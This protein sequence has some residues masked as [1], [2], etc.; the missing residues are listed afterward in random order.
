M[1]KPIY[2]SEEHRT[3]VDTYLMV[4]QDFA[5][6]VSTKSKYNNYLDV[7]ET[8]IEYHNSYG[9]GIRENN[10]Y[11]WLVIIP[12]NVSV[13]TN[14]FFAGLET[15]SNR[16]TVRAYKTVLDDMVGDV[17]DKIDSLEEPSE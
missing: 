5:K 3:I 16:A 14:G 6:D 7:L 8:I 17:V 13:M 4:C 11:D 2:A 10:W 12:I 15:N 9:S 1:T